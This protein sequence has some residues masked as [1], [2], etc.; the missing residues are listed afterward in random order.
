MNARMET[1]MTATAPLPDKSLPDS[2]TLAGVGGTKSRVLSIQVL[3]GFA[4]CAV[5]LYHTDIILGHRN[6]G[7]NSQFGGLA[8]WGW[9][10][11][12]LFF[13]ISG[14]T[15]LLAHHRDVGVP[16]RLARYSWRRFVRVYPIYWLM[17]VAFLIATYFKPDY[18]PLDLRPGNLLTTVMLLPFVQDPEL[19]LKVAWSML[20]EVMFYGLFAL[21]ILSRHASRLLWPLW[22]VAILVSVFVFHRYALDPLNVY[23]L[24]FILGALL[25]RAMPH[26]R[27]SA[28]IPLL[29]GL[30]I[31]CVAVSGIVGPRANFDH[32]NLALFAV[33]LP[34]LF[35][36][37]ICLVAE[38]AY[39][40]LFS[41]PTLL[42]IGDASYSIYLVH[43]AV[44]S[45]AG[46]LQSK[47]LMWIPGVV[48]FVAAGVGSVIVGIGVHLY[49]EKPILT[50]L[51]DRLSARHS[52]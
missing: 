17:A 11:V 20:F 13:M 16:Q 31:S 38:K 41:S 50:R 4:A 45:V 30:G 18:R 40:R 25:W 19:P 10:G 29:L 42:L 6:Y 8:E 21:A 7:T 23:N 24:Y 3:R 52:A 5:V 51:R 15:I 35:V 27:A 36:L 33:A 48:Y 9:L 44:L 22:T 46:S 39:P 14:F 12:N 2:P 34:V 26:L 47:A 43:S 28:L 32:D 37:A 49:I 1:A